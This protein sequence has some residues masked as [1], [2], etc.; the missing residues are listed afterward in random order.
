VVKYATE[1]DAYIDQYDKEH[2]SA[3]FAERFASWQVWLKEHENPPE[4]LQPAYDYWIDLLAFFEVEGAGLWPGAIA[5]LDVEVQKL[6]AKYREGITEARTA[7]PA[8]DDMMIVQALFP[9]P[10][11]ATPTP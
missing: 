9:L 4:L 11:P 3:S 6:N 8:I 7:C 1:F 5:D 10:T 2:E